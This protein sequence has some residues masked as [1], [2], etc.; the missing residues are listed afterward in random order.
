MIIKSTLWEQFFIRIL[1]EMI[2]GNPEDYLFSS[3]RNYAELDHVLE[4]CLISKRWKTYA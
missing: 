4:V 3:A 1:E 2:V